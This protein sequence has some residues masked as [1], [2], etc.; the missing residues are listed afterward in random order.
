MARENHRYSEDHIRAAV[1]HKRLNFSEFVARIEKE[2]DARFS[3]YIENLLLI[4][5]EHYLDDKFIS[6]S[7]A[8][9]FIPMA[10]S[11]TCMRYLTE[12]EDRG[13]VKF[14]QDERDSRRTNVVPTDQL[15]DHVRSKIE[16]DIDDAR[17]FI[18]GVARKKPLP[19]DNH[20]FAEY[21]K[22]PAR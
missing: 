7:Q 18:D 20:P 14:V 10:H 21:P 11:N 12:A 16:A 5:Y 13:F 22:Q 15:L 3:Y 17:E 9:K 8:C 4:I 2:N 6:K 19:K 1:A